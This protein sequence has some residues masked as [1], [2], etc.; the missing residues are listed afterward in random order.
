MKQAGIVAPTGT[1]KK[2]QEQS[3]KLGLPTTVV[4]PIIVEGWKGKPKGLLQ[5]LYE[6]EWIN[7][8]CTHLYTLEGRKTDDAANNNGVMDPTGCN[9]SLK[10]LMKLQHDFTEETTL[11]QFHGKLMGA[12]AD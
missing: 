1:G 6:R 10:K 8:D 2:L 12:T 9:F 3:E 11:L 5:V 7:P 4:E